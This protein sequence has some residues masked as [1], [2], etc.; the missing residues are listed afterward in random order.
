MQKK[1][2]KLLKPWQ[3]GTYLRV[4]GE[5]FQIF[6]GELLFDLCLTFLLQIF[7]KKV[8]CLKNISKIVRLAALSVNGLRSIEREVD[9]YL[10]ISGA[11]LTMVC[12]FLSLL[13][14]FVRRKY[15]LLLS[16]F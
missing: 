4:L 8:F 13:K 15:R 1:P 5:S 16:Y 9:G 3:M 11:S 7:S 10:V 14:Q 2:E 12:Q 6:E